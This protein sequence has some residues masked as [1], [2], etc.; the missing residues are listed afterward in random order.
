[1]KIPQIVLGE[2]IRIEHNIDNGELF[3]VFKILDPQLKQEILRDWTQ[4]INLKLYGRNLI[5]E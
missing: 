4:E 3:L 5:N 2:A 1:M